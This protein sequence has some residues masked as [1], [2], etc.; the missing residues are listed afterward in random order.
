MSVILQLADI[1]SIE[2]LGYHNFSLVVF[3]AG[4]FNVVLIID[5]EATH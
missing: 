3:L 2:L 1:T 4:E 5:L